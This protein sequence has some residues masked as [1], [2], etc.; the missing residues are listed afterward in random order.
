MHNLDAD[1]AEILRPAIEAA[2]ERDEDAHYTRIP[3]GIPCPA[4]AI[5]ACRRILTSTSGTGAVLDDHHCPRRLAQRKM[6]RK[7]PD[8]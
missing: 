5:A 2:A 4:R 7:C 3:G 6:L 1:A 8:C